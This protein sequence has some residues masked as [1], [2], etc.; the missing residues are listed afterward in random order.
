MSSIRSNLGRIIGW[1]L[2]GSFTVL[3]FIKSAIV[4]FGPAAN[5]VHQ[6][7]HFWIIMFRT[8]TQL[9]ITTSHL[10]KIYTYQNKNLGYNVN[11]T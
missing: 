8:E 7:R 10:E 5:F 9:A 11:N 1:I 6:Q 2:N 4:N 3:A